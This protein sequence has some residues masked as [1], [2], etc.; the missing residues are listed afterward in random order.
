VIYARQD[1]IPFTR[2]VLSLDAGTSADPAQA[3]GTQQLMLAML[4]QGTGRFDAIGIAQEEERL[5]ARIG[6]GASL[7]RTTLTLSTPSATAPEALSLLADVTCTLPL[8]TPN[9]PASATS[10]WPASRRNAP[11]PPA[12][13]TAPSPR[14]SMARTIPMPARK[15]RAIRRWWQ[16]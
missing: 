11:A 14:C 7:D 8:P 1:A 12:S 13:A 6:V 3:I 10:C 15:G 2:A 5:G 9:W 16:S 4:K